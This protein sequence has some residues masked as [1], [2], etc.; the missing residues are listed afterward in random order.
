M[1]NKLVEIPSFSELMASKS[2]YVLQGVDKTEFYQGLAGAALT[3]VLF[4]GVAYFGSKR[5]NSDN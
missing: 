1:T 3:G 2:E 4:A 5:T